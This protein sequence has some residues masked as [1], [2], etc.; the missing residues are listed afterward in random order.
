ML[1]TRPTNVTMTVFNLWLGD[2]SGNVCDLYNSLKVK[3]TISFHDQNKHYHYR[4]YNVTPDACL[5]NTFV[6][7]HRN[8]LLNWLDKVEL[9]VFDVEN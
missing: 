6:I 2:N 8:F 1:K 4:I 3:V 5:E 9:G 7:C